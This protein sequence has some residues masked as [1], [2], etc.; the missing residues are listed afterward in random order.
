MGLFSDL[1]DAVLHKIFVQYLKPDR[2]NTRLF[3]V[4]TCNKDTY[5]NLSQR[6]DLMQLLVDILDG[7]T[8]CNKED[9]GEVRRSKRLKKT[10]LESFG[11]AMRRRLMRWDSLAIEMVSLCTLPGKEVLTKEKFDKLVKS[12]QPTDIDHVGLASES[13]VLMEIVKARK[14]GD[15]S[16]MK[17]VKQC[18]ETFGADV[19][20]GNQH[21]INPLI[22]SAARGLPNVC[23][24]LLKHGADPTL[25]GKG[26]FVSY[27]YPNN[28]TI[29]SPPKKVVVK[30]TYTAGEWARAMQDAEQTCGGTSE[31]EN[32]PSGGPGWHE[33]P[34]VGAGSQLRACSWLIEKHEAVAQNSPKHRQR[35]T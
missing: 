13:T 30:G 5:E 28:G 8:P 9:E 25:K 26:S 16:I 12:A 33:G 6:Q 31:V 11:D 1:P 7:K 21:G 14:M 19:N 20:K 23:K 10:P 15:V 34:P 4:L 27:V 32:T 35:P 29:A 3:A 17:C 18:V 24:F 2:W 22:L